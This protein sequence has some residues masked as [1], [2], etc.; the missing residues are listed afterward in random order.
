MILEGIEKAH[1]RLIR[2]LVKLQ[3]EVRLAKIAFYATKQLILKLQGEIEQ[4]KAVRDALGRS[5]KNALADRNTFIKKVEVL[6]GRI[7]KAVQ[8]DFEFLWKEYGLA[9]DENLTKDAIC[10]KRLLFGAVEKVGLKRLTELE[11]RLEAI[12]LFVKKL[13]QKY[14]EQFEAERANHKTALAME[15]CAERDDLLSHSWG[16]IKLLKDI[17]EGL[18]V[19]LSEPKNEDKQCPDCKGT[20]LD[21][22]TYDEHIMGGAFHMYACKCKRC[23]GTGKAEPKELDQ[24]MDICKKNNA[25]ACLKSGCEHAEAADGQF[26]CHNNHRGFKLEEPKGEADLTSTEASDV[27]V[28]REEIRQGKAKKFANTD[29]LLKELKEGK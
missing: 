15:P 25:Y 17:L 2:D 7:E 14:V 22:N 20:G 21:P 28:S 12:D 8:G 24:K 4:L 18:G 19:L 6:E 23:K 26:I 11:E 13:N 29:A 27:K 10:L 1:L 5:N 3:E 9:S 16:R